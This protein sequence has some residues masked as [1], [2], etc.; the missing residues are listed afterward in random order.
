MV[1]EAECEWVDSELR[2]FLQPHIKVPY[3][4]PQYKPECSF[5][6][7]IEHSWAGESQ[8]CPPKYLIWKFGVGNMNG[9]DCSMKAPEV[10]YHHSIGEVSL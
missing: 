9:I 6:L 7:P 2:L 1:A 4:W 3:A 10:N 8:V 5:F